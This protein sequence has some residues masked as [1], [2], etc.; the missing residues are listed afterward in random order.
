MLQALYLRIRRTTP[1]R[2]M[3]FL[4]DVE[5]VSTRVFIPSS[6]IVVVLGF[7]L[8]PRATGISVRP[9]STSRSPSTSRRF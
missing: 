8:R 4:G 6:L 5:I 9:G 3:E 7:G 1:D 2:V